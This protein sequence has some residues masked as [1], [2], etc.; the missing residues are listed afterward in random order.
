MNV[1][2]NGIQADGIRDAR[3]VQSADSARRKPRSSEPHRQTADDA[4]ISEEALML[5]K[6]RQA[7]SDCPDVRG[8]KVAA[9]R[10]AVEKGIYR[11][12]PV[13]IARAMLGHHKESK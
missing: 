5:Q 12:S 10:I 8:E 7:V 2:N 3:H 9:L 13:E 4:T 6:A 11:P 1:F